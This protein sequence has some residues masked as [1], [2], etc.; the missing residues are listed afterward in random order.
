[1][2][3]YNYIV[4]AAL[5]ALSGY[6]FWDTRDWINGSNFQA[7]PG[8]W[9]QFLAMLLAVLS[10]ALIIETIFSKDPGMDKDV[11]DWKSPG[12]IVVY[13]MMGIMLGFLVL[14]EILGMLI[15][16]L[17]IIPIIM[18]LMGCRSKKT[19]VILP[20]AVV[21]FVYLFFGVIMRITLPEPFFL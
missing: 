14:M 11:I 1:M 2:R 10:I 21:S 12:M 3:K 8:F 9:P 15:G 18:Y 5:L 4:S 17:V 13:K 7:R 19:L 6:I 20:V 16:L